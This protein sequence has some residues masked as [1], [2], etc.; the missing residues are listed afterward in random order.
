VIL[1]DGRK[2]VASAEVNPD[3]FWGLRGGGGNF[4]V[5]T[6]FTFRMHDLGQVLIGNWSYSPSDAT[7]VLKAFGECT[8]TAPTN[9]T[10]AISLTEDA[11]RVT[12]CWSGSGG[13][14]GRTVAAYGMLREPQTEQVGDMN[15]IQLQSR[16][17]EQLRWGRRYYAKG[18]FLET[19]SNDVIGALTD[20]MKG[21]PTP[22]SKI[23]VIQLGGAISAVDENA[24]AYSGRAANYY[25]IVEPVWDQPEDDLRCLAWGRSTAKSLSAISLATNY[26]NEQAD[27]DGSVAKAAYGADKY[28]R[29]ARLKATYDPGN[30]FK[31]NQNIEPARP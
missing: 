9:L 5:V 28:A 14:A 12:A 13:D 1:A 27:S 16:G 2:V 22:D 24:T 18:G 11:L 26:V 6:E 20:A 19:L 3:L 31:L 4:G 21:A 23:N 25:W 17:D 10:T 8:T 7:N 15:F 29:L 30:L